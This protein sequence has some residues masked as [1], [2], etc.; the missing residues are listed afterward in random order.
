M[1]LHRKV[2]VGSYVRPRRLRDY[3]RFD[4]LSATPLRAAFAFFRFGLGFG[5]GFGVDLARIVAEVEASM[6]DSSYASRS[7]SVMGAST[8]SRCLI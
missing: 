3:R 2:Y 8:S 6:S 5:L 1:T 7:Q 4:F